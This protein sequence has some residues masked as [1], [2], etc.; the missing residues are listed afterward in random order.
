MKILIISGN[1]SRH[2][3]IHK[4]VLQSG[5]ECAAIVMEREDIVPKPPE[6]TLLRDA[7]NF[8]LHFKER[9]YKEKKAFG[10]LNPDDVFKDILVKKCKPEHLNSIEMSKFVNEFSPDIAF[11][12]GVDIIKDPLMRSLPNIKVNLHLGLSPWYKGSATLF[13]PFY[14]VQPHYAGVTFHN[15][16]KFADAGDILHQCVPKL[17]KGDGI[18][19]VS[20][21]AVI[22]AKDDL[23]KLL[24]IYSATKKWNFFKQKTTGRLFLT[25]DFK[26][27]HLRVIYD[28]FDN[29][30]I[31]FFYENKILMKTPR[32]IDGI[33]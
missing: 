11:I 30:M 31:D 33:N 4:A 2:L 25:T 14:F 17:S 10:D 1:H 19:D 13:W 3:Y 5:Y 7:K 21:K 23:L 16:T 24:E 28:L 29:K 18:H 9:F 15:I 26:P 32:I 20:V 8:N 6:K 27:F 22:K 12:F